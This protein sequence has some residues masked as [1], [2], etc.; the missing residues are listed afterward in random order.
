MGGLRIKAC[1]LGAIVDGGSVEIP[2]GR[3][4]A[5]GLEEGR[6]VEVLVR[7]EGVILDIEG[8]EGPVIHVISTHLLVHD[9]IVRVRLSDET[10]AKE[11]EKELYVRAHHSFEPEL[12]NRITAGVD[13]EYAFIFP[14]DDLGGMAGAGYTASPQPEAAD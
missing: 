4:Q 11:E 13:P 3:V 5:H 12:S 9:N 2:L 7:P 14:T 8:K 1:L 6:R 10:G